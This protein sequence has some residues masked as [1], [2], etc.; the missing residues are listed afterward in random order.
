MSLLSQIPS[1]Q[2]SRVCPSLLLP[3]TL[4][5]CPAFSGGAPAAATAVLPSEPEIIE[6]PGLDER[7]FVGP[8]AEVMERL[9]PEDDGWDTEA[10]SEAASAQLYRFGALLKSRDPEAAAF[11]NIAAKNFA[12]PALR[13][14]GDTL[15]L[16]KGSEFEV[17]KWN[18]AEASS[19]Q[20]SLAEARRQF[21]SAF[22][23]D[24]ELQVKTK[25]Y[26]VMPQAEGVTLTDVLVEA[27]GDAPSA[28]R[29]QI[30]AE[31]RCHWEK[32]GEEP[33]LTKIELL[34]YQ[35]VTRPLGGGE[36]LFSDQTRAALGNNASLDE[37]LLHSTDHWRARIPQS[38]G[39]DVVANVGFLIADLNG[40]DLE[41]L[42]LC[43]Q[44]GLPNL[45]FLRQEDGTYVDASRG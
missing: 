39:L 31:W 26:K 32:G 29:R 3:W 20:L 41:D 23:S 24:A 1:R 5:L 38:F 15:D 16:I 33:L 19:Q 6:A 18:G 40:D 28:G 44:G 8:L 2:I 14:K 34:H 25:L 30:N 35:E 7:E 22:A 10:F 4:I 42:Y 13:P 12:A 11:V 17:S 9:S 37:Q 36:P 43:Q 21:R 27:A 45:L